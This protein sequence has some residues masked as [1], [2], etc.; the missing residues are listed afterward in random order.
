MVQ[1]TPLLGGMRVDHL[2]P[3]R[4]ETVP[5]WLQNGTPMYRKRVQNGPKRGPKRT[6]FRVLFDAR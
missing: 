5:E 4:L 1:S 2:K 3:N 6:T